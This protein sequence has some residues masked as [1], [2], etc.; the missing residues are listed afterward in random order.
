MH[1][2]STERI[3]EDLLLG[4]VSEDNGDTSSLNEQAEARLPTVYG[5]FRMIAFSDL[6]DDPMPHL[7]LVAAGTDLSGPVLVRV[8][9]ECMT[10]DV[11][12]SLRC[13][14]GDQ[15]AWAMRET[16]THGGVIVYL[17]QE[18]R[19]IGIIN[20]LRA[21]GLQDAGAD[22]IEANV[23][24]GLPVD[25]RDYTDALEILRRLGVEQIKLMTNN[26]LKIEAFAGSPVEVLERIPIEMPRQTENERY[27]DTKRDEM[28]H[29][30]H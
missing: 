28:G 29:Q 13:D 5:E 3:G 30:L 16:S 20:K 24:L 7:A 12:A 27:L 4:G 26:P 10:G 19:G 23:A 6:D 17:R 25:G 9:S 22:T 8:H 14:C 11:F 21:Y 2:N 1:T 18:G 15:L